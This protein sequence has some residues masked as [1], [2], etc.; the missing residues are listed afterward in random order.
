MTEPASPAEPA[1]SGRLA[2]MLRA[3]R[4]RN[5]RLFFGGQIVSLMGNW[6]TTI[7]TSWLVHRWIVVHDG[8][9]W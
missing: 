5:Y 8:A 6:M 4:Y 9:T 7:A 3:L 1:G 2:F